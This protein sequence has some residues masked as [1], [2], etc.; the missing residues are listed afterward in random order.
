MNMYKKG[1]DAARFEREEELE[2]LAKNN[3]A[4]VTVR[5]LTRKLSRTESE[6]ARWQGLRLEESYFSSGMPQSEEDATLSFVRDS[7]LHFMS[8][9]PDTHEHLKAL[10]KIFKYSDE[11]L[12]KVWKG[13][14]AFKNIDRKKIMDKIEVPNG[15]NQSKNG[16]K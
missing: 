16:H 1:L 14:E 11:Q 8:D 7:F 9:T 4:N 12:G 3:K 6:L 13:L 15:T 5:E 10:L 2:M